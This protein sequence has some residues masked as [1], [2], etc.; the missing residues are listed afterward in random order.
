MSGNENVNRYGESHIHASKAQTLHDPNYSWS[1]DP[2]SHS[3]DESERNLEHVWANF[4]SH[5]ELDTSGI[6]ASIKEGCVHLEG[7]VQNREQKILAETLTR[8]SENVIEVVNELKEM[9]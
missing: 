5:P 6:K 2:R 7:Y 3:F 1:K 9:V 4:L 8:G